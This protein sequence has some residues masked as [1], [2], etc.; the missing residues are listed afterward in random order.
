[1]TGLDW[2]HHNFADGRLGD[3]AHLACGGRMRRLGLKAV[4]FAGLPR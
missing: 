1:M 4:P 2:L 3:V